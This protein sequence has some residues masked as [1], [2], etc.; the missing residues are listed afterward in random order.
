MKTTFPTAA[1]QVGRT[2]S[3]TI[4]DP[5]VDTFNNFFDSPFAMSVPKA[6]VAEKDNEIQIDLAVPGL[7]KE[8]FTIRADGNMLTVSAQKE[9]SK[10]E[11]DDPKNYRR[12]C[13]YSSFSR[14]F[15]LPDSAKVDQTKAIYKDGILTIMATKTDTPKKESKAI[16]VE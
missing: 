6:N 10:T 4:I 3:T 1:Q 13:N 8:E 9:S 14:S 7:K 15:M 2:L 12:E 16:T 11:N 5:L